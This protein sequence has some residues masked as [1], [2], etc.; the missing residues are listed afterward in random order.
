M[1]I[2][3]YLPRLDQA[4]YGPPRGQLNN[5]SLKS[6]AALQCD[7]QPIAANEN[8]SRLQGSLMGPLADNHIA[9]PHEDEVHAKFAR[10]V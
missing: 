6:V 9:R 8:V 3:K 5:E 2:R 4:V 10:D 1:Q 7:R